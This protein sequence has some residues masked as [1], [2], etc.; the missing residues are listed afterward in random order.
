M[1]DPTTP[2]PP[3]LVDSANDLWIYITD[4]GGEGVDPMYFLVGQADVFNDP[5]EIERLRAAEQGDPSMWVYE[6]Y[7]W[8]RDAHGPITER[9]RG[10]VGEPAPTLP[11][12]LVDGDGDL[13]LVVG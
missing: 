13:N 2:P 5:D 10:P 12:D 11:P 6:R 1:T 3:D 7:E 4:M 9:P 8:I